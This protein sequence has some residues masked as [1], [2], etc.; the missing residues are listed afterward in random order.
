MKRVHRYNLLSLFGDLK[1][2]PYDLVVQL[3]TLHFANPLN[4]KEI[5]GNEKL[6]NNSYMST[7]IEKMLN[8]LLED[9]LIMRVE[10]EGIKTLRLLDYYQI[11]P[12]DWAL[13]LTDRGRN[14]LA[15]EQIERSGDK[16]WYQKYDGSLDSAAKINPG[17]FK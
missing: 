17:L 16:D 10:T 13:Q 11:S 5:W 1:P 8:K 7:E 14:C 4:R 12:R 15:N 2:K 9:E 6:P 3:A